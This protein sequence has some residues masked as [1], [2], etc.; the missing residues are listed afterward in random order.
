[1]VLG[2]SVKMPYMLWGMTYTIMDI[3]YGD[4]FYDI[5]A[6]VT[7]KKQG[8]G[9]DE[10]TTK[11]LM[12]TIMNHNGHGVKDGDVTLAPYESRIEKV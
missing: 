12:N 2:H 10:G 5:Y 4:T 9:Q 1:M 6:A 8:D 3:P 11:H 7:R